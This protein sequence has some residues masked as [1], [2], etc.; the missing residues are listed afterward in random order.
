MA[1]PST[2]YRGCMLVDVVALRRDGAKLPRDVVLAATPIR[3]HL[4]IQTFRAGPH[5][6]P[7]IPAETVQALL[8]E[9]PG[10]TWP[11]LLSLAQVRITSLQGLSFVVV[12]TEQVG[13]PTLGRRKPQAW[14]CRAV[15]EDEV[16]T[17]VG[18]SAGGSA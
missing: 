14:W 18:E 13:H 12:G 4:R 2:R 5:R 16:R 7:D 15:L 3:G 17:S 1:E 11:C 8:T 9:D 6:A 10:A